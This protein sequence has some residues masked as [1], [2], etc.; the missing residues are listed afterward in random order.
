ML[1]VLLLIFSICLYAAILS[2]C[3][4]FHPSPLTQHTHS[5]I[6]GICYFDIDGTLISA[7]G[8]RDEIIQVCLDN[9]FAVG[10]ITASARKIDHI[11]NGNKGRFNWMPDLLCK[12]F[13]E[14]GGKMYNSV[15]IV[16]GDSIFPGNYPHGASP[17][18]IKGFNMKYGRD[19]FYPHVPDNMVVL[20]DDQ[21]PV[22]DGVKQFNPN[23][24]TQNVCEN[25]ACIESIPL[26]VDVVRKKLVDIL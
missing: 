11:C 19:K 12:Q 24:Q 21:Q 23:F 20:F 7:T 2:F 16:A 26:S 14:N 22:L 15:V 18:Y 5:V 4:Q 10:I 25:G 9:N 1:F 17:G 13:N 3:N 6:K 8:D